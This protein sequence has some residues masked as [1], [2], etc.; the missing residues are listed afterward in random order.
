M[1]KVAEEKTAGGMQD[2][3]DHIKNALD[4]VFTSNSFAAFLPQDF[5][6]LSNYTRLRH[7]CYQAGHTGHWFEGLLIMSVCGSGMWKHPTQKSL[8]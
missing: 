4:G 5:P 2:G 6:P 1:P 8:K 3:G 7:N